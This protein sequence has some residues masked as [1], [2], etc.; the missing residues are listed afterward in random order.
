MYMRS[1][2]WRQEIAFIAIVFLQCLP[3]VTSSQSSIN[4]VRSKLSK[5]ELRW[6]QGDKEIASWL[7]IYRDE[8]TAVEKIRAK[9]DWRRQLGKV[10]MA[11]CARGF[12][13]DGFTVCLESLH[14]RDG[15]AIVYS[16]GLP[17]G[18][19]SQIRAQTIYLQERVLANSKNN[20]ASS[21]TVIDCTQPSFRIPDGTLK[22][23][24]IDVISTYYPWSTFGATVFIGVPKPV[25]SLFKLTKPLFPK[26]TFERFRF[27][28]TKRDLIEY[29]PADQLPTS[30]GGRAFWSLRMYTTQ[31]CLVEGTLCRPAPR[32][33]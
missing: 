19:E 10:S 9:A 6:I 8:K 13:T 16:H 20:V 14:D 5:E 32:D 33:L 2:Q 7:S 3:A 17:R 28:D 26:E 24:G 21:L 25:Q 22:R 12:G 1:K 30:W 15:N 4:S 23:G 18:T 11:D 31:R 27:A 29:I